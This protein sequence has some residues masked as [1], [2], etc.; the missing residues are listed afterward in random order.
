MED[1][2]KLQ[3]WFAQCGHAQLVTVVSALLNQEH[4]N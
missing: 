4:Q 3:S 1:H 2:V